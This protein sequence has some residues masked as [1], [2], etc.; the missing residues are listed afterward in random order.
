MATKEPKKAAP[1][2]SSSKSKKES[3]AAEAS[4]QPT[5]AARKSS[6]KALRFAKRRPQRAP[7]TGEATLRFVRISPQKA[8]LA[9][10]M[11][12]GQQVEPALQML[13]FSPKK[14]TRIVLKVLESAIANAREQGGAD[15]DR[16]WVVGGWVNM[17]RS[18]KR[19]M[20]RA[21]GSATPI[22]KRSS[23]ITV[24]VAEKGR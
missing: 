17:G 22:I 21:R 20:P 23:Q 7:G 24:Q 16:L 4:V 8:R 14:S 3:A 11:I 6:S 9:L 19:F 18:I 1:R 10:N 13:R 5:A 15:V 2:K 12:R